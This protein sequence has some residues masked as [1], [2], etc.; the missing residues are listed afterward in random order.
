M[1]DFTT[2][3]LRAAGAASGAA[4]TGAGLAAGAGAAAC[5]GMCIMMGAWLE[6]PARLMRTDSS[7]SLI[8]SSPMLD[9]SSSSISFFILR[10][11]MID[12]WVEAGQCDAWLLMAVL[13]VAQLGEGGAQ[14]QFVADWPE[15]ADQPPSDVGKIGLVTEGFPGVHIGEVYLD[16]GNIRAQQSIPQSHTGVG[17]GGGV[18]NDE[19][20]T[21]L[22]GIV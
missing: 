12:S 8:S 9:S 3:P 22:A 15:A 18:E 17:E 2:W 10:I 16:K 21:F 1:G 13:S 14:G 11:S 20:D 5:W 4:A 7:P 19:I 6:K